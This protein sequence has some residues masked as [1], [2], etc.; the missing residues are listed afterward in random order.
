[1]L[2]LEPDGRWTEDPE[3]ITELLV[4]AA[5][6]Q[7]WVVS[8]D[9]LKAWLKRLAAPIR[10]RLAL[11]HG[12]RWI[13]PDPSPAARRLAI[14]LQGMVRD[15]AR[16]HNAKRLEQLEAALAFVAG[17]HTA[18]EE[19]LVETLAT[20]TDREISAALGRL[21]ASTIRCDGIEV[22]LTGLIV[23]GTPQPGTAKLASPECLDLKPRSSTSTEP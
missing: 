14:R 1:V 11:A 19:A 22:R 18:G 2:W 9:Y 21:P 7:L 8:D 23:F 3:T 12:R 17:G 16:R 15:A 13:K 5:S 4:A 10:E 6:E 20:G